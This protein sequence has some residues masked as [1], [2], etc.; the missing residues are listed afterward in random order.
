MYSSLYFAIRVSHELIKE[1]WRIP[2]HL[3]NQRRVPPPTASR[4]PGYFV[5]DRRGWRS[6]AT[7]AVQQQQFATA[8]MLSKEAKIDVLIL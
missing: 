4:S 8:A 3:R 2:L 5:A 7:D 1:A 6:E